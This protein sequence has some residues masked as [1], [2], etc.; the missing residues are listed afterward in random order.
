MKIASVADVKAHFSAYMKE[1]E[2]GP[3]VITRNGKP[4]A[5]LVNIFDEDELDGLILAYSPKFRAILQAARAEIQQTGGIP[6]D[7]FWSAIDAEY[8]DEEI[9]N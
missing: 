8:D 7:E 1:S 3:V 5:V 4:A 9:D 2:S 6:H